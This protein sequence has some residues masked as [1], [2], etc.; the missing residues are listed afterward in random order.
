M[1]I[2]T[3]GEPTAQVAQK[4]AAVRKRA[5]KQASSL[6]FVIRLHVIV[7]ETASK[8][9]D[10]ANNLIKYVDEATIQKS[11][12][13]F[14]RMDSHRLLKILPPSLNNIG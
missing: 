11:Q 7:R 4:I 12:Q 9:W 3:W 13:A 2:L 14:A 5:E 8:A 1:F 10:A 6:R